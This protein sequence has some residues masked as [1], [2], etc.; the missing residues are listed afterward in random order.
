MRASSKMIMTGA[1]QMMYPMYLPLK[2]EVRKADWK[3]GQNTTRMETMM[4]QG[5]DML[6]YLLSSPF[7]NREVKRV[8]THIMHAIW[9]S[10]MVKR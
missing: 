7:L 4:E 10:M 5:K 2:E 1:R 6:T 9:P 8:L 3:G